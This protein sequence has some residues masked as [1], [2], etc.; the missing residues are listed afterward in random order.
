MTACQ[1][2]HWSSSVPHCFCV[3]VTAFMLDQNSCGI[4]SIGVT[5]HN[6]TSF[7]EPVELYF[8]YSFAAKKTEVRVSLSIIMYP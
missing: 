2:H 1:P 7:S 8:F 6:K 5:F 4:F 3:K